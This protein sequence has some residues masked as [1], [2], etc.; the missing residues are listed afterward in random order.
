[1]QGDDQVP[2][3]RQVLISRIHLT[4]LHDAQVP[5]LRF[6]GIREL[7]FGIFGTTIALPGDVFWT[8]CGPRGAAA[9]DPWADG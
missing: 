4:L 9:T 2:T 3:P 7:V 6:F 8:G 5:A 1:M